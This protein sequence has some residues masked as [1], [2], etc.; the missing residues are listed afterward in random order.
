MTDS[1][2]NRFLASGTNAERLAFTP[3]PPTPASGPDPTYI[4][5]E[6]DT[7]NT[8]CWNFDSA[9]WVK[10][11]NAPTATVPHAL[12][13]NNSGSG[14]ASGSTF[15]GSVAEVVSY[16]TVGAQASDATL[17]ALAAMSYTSGTLAVTLTA[18]DTF[19]LKAVGAGSGNILDKT[20]GDSLYQPLGSYQPTDATLTALAALSWTAG[21]QVLS[22]TAADTF[23]LK[24]VGSASGN[25]LD[26][27]AG[28]ALYQ[29]LSTA[30]L[31]A[32]NL[33]DVASAATALSNLGG[34]PLDGDL[35]SLAAA[36]GTNTIYYRSAANTWSSVSF[37]PVLTFTSGTL[38]VTSA[39]EW[40]PNFTAAGDLYIPAIVAMTVDQGNAAIGTGTITY[41]KSTAAAPSTFSSTTLPATLEAGAWL[42]VTAASVTGFVATHLKRTA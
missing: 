38:G 42:K 26:K 8:Y 13:F 15:D 17:T 16:N 22:L 9:A 35:T 37:G 33:S 2:L 29:P 18:A 39:K 5:H 23:T 40:A 19:T 10:I 6:T 31:K 32:S 12:T 27:A 24:T 34:Q 28:D 41:F 25:I 3:A 20:A 1:T 21:T 30:L 4:W 36:S 7:S 11:N 14:V